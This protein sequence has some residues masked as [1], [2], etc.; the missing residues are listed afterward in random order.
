[1]REVR[2]F[3]KVGESVCFVMAESSGESFAFLRYV[4]SFSLYLKVSG[5]EA[6]KKVLFSQGDGEHVEGKG[7]LN[8]GVVS[9]W[10]RS[11]TQRRR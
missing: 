7:P 2:V 9:A 8:H 1:M 4:H 3:S 6:S 5:V 10:F 11:Q